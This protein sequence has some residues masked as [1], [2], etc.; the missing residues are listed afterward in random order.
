MKEVKVAGYVKNS[1][2]DW[3]ARISFV[4]FLGG[5]NFRCPH[6]HN[7]N[8]WGSMSNKLPYM[9][10]RKDAPAVRDLIK[11]QVGFIDGVVISGGEPTIHPH[12]FDIIKDIR[13]MGLDVKLDTNGSNY[14]VL[15]LLVE[16]GL[17][18]AVAMDIKAP[19]DKYVEYG[20]IPRGAKADATL[21]NVRRS[22]EYLKEKA[23]SDAIGVYFRTT[24]VPC[25][26]PADLAAVRALAG[27]VPYSVNDFIPVK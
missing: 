16:E 7:H 2:V 5:C 18:N 12:I 11:E 9:W 3:R 25:L 24:P 23:A 8:I 27:D 17:V 20:F 6:C 4:L 10:G 14:G 15:N 26:T 13:A 22:V 1:F 19:L 21:E